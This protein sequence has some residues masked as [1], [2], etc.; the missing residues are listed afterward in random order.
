M[1]LRMIV[2]SRKPLSKDNLSGYRAWR[3]GMKQK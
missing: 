2:E 1:Q 3:S